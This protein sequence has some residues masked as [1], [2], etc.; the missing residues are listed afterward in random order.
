MQGI[1]RSSVNSPRKVQWRG[2]LMFSLIWAWINGWVVMLVIWDATAPILTSLWWSL[3]AI[4]AINVVHDLLTGEHILVDP[5]EFLCRY[6]CKS[7]L[8]EV[9]VDVICPQAILS[10][11]KICDVAQ[12][13]RPLSTLRISACRV[14]WDPLNYR[15]LTRLFNIL[16]IHTSQNTSKLRITCPLHG[17]SDA[18]DQFRT[19]CLDYYRS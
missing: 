15:Q 18:V 1:H 13:L 3:T 5:H 2:A 14:C 7:W 19:K 9:P 16:S 12:T 6:P 10:Q 11:H 4:H 8:N 17:K